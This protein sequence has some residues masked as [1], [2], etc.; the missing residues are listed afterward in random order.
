MPSR[1]DGLKIPKYELMMRDWLY[2]ASSWDVLGFE[3]VTRQ[4]Q[5]DNLTKTRGQNRVERHS[6]GKHHLWV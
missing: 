2:T 4:R 3:A 6:T 1:W 5:H